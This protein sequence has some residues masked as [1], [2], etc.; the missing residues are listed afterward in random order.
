MKLTCEICGG[1]LE[2]QAG[3]H[4]VICLDCGLTYSKKRLQELIAQSRAEGAPE[5]RP[6]YGQPDTDTR[7]DRIEAEDEAYRY[8]APEEGEVFC[9]FFPDLGPA[10]IGLPEPGGIDPI[11]LTELEAW[12]KL[13]VHLPKPEGDKRWRRADYG[14]ARYADPEPETDRWA[15]GDVQ[16]DSKDASSVDPASFWKMA[17]DLGPAGA[18]RIRK[19]FVG[20]DS[21]RSGTAWAEEEPHRR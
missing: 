20:P 15:A 18:S 19:E 17:G 8:S 10:D 21:M 11:S 2:V 4:L 7:E 5:N 3:G 1:T 9:S 13:P 14:R 12:L 16:E 6:E